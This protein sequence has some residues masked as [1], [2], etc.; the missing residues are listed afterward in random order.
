MRVYTL[1][2]G[3]SGNLMYFSTY[4]R[5]ESYLVFC[6]FELVSPMD[7]NAKAVYREIISQPNLFRLEPRRALIGWVDVDSALRDWHN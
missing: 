2:I 1:Q 3:D 5:A 6:G 4:E 7:D